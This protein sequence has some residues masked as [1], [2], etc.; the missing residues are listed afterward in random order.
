MKV[1]F[2]TVSFL[3]LAGVLSLSSC[4]NPASA[5]LSNKALARSAMTGTVVS[6]QVVSLDLPFAPG[7]LVAG[8]PSVQVNYTTPNMTNTNVFLHL[9]L[10]N[11]KTIQDI[12]MTG[13]LY[14]TGVAILNA[15]FSLP[16]GTTEVEYCVYQVLAD[17]TKVWDNNGGQ[18]YV[19]P[20]S[21]SAAG[22]VDNADGS[23]TVSYAGALSPAYLHWGVNGWTNVQNTPMTLSATPVLPSGLN[24]YTVTLTGLTSGEPLN[25]CFT[26]LNGVWDNNN[27]QNWV[28]Y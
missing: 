22:A 21:A 3:A 25:Y 5:N 15:K 19:D 28:S 23:R 26:N 10:N 20:V 1:V 4:S 8:D 14:Q 17:G 7:T 18:N 13:D 24:L 12:P 6:T 9:G 27:Q 16:L 2:A 11:W